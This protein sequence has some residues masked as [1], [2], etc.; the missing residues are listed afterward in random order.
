MCAGL[1]WTMNVNDAEVESERAAV[2]ACMR[3]LVLV[4]IYTPSASFFMLHS[5]HE[6]PS[7]A[8]CVL[9]VR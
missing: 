6:W 2:C 3:T 7:S 5:P 9:L 4:C 1:W 8:R